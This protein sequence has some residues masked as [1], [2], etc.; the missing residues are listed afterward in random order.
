LPKDNQ[1]R[2]F[3]QEI[4]AEMKKKKSKAR[5]PAAPKA[6]Q[7]FEA[8]ALSVQQRD[9]LLNIDGIDPMTEM[10]LNSIGIRQF[11]D[12]QRHT[13]ETL[14]QALQERT[15]LAISA[16][17]IARQDWIGSAA[18]LASVNNGTGTACGENHVLPEENSGQTALP[19]QLPFASEQEIPPASIAGAEVV[20]KLE[21]SSQEISTPD[22]T[23]D[24]S[25]R[26]V[27]PDTQSQ[28]AR[29]HKSQ[30]NAD[31]GFQAL[32]IQHAAFA[33]IERP[34]KPNH[35]AMKFLRSEIDCTLIGA[36][37]MTVAA[38]F[39][40]QVHAVDQA[41]G[42]YKLLVSQVEQLPPGQ[43]DYQVRLEYAVPGLGRYQLLAIAFLLQA[44]SGI[45]LYQGPLLRVVA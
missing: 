3:I 44:D 12:F 45:A 29:T 23:Y 1:I 22:A 21:A 25:T 38:P 32:R 33:P 41:T 27:T 34:A 16:E 8:P 24:T 7:R 15:G 10:A 31:T 37:A 5:T 11:A 19:N 26:D 28:D 6:A 20:N 43:T 35:P 13:P 4:C 40:A 36:E 39:C 9:D 30:E 17:S 18:I 14:A 2:V 42:E